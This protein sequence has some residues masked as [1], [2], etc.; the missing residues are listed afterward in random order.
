MMI[1]QSCTRVIFSCNLFRAPP[2][3]IY[4]D[5]PAKNIPN[6]PIVPAKK[7]PNFFLKTGSGTSRAPIRLSVGFLLAKKS[8]KNRKK[9]FLIFLSFCPSNRDYEF[10]DFFFKIFLYFFPKKYKKIK[11]KSGNLK[12]R[13]GG[14]KLKKIKNRFFLFFCDFFPNRNPTDSLI[15][16][17]EVPEPGFEN[18]WFFLLVQLENWWFFLQVHLQV[19]L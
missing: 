6:F 7:T 2:A 5:V 14:Q 8:Q 19:L 9:R 1:K 15:G 12:S 16:P 11:K 17:R 18:W 10:L 4:E 3:Y 13:F